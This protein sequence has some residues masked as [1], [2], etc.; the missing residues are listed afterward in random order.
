MSQFFGLLTSSTLTP[1]YSYRAQEICSTSHLKQ[2]GRISLM[3]FGCVLLPELVFEKTCIYYTNFWNL[4]VFNRFTHWNTSK[5]MYLSLLYPQEPSV[6]D[7]GQ[8]L[9][10]SFFRHFWQ[11]FRSKWQSMNLLF[12]MVVSYTWGLRLKIMFYDVF[13]CP[14]ALETFLKWF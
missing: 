11:F 6:N 13:L 1:Y 8:N 14:R 9:D 12:D 7:P 3:K 4:L 5:I 10:R 2:K